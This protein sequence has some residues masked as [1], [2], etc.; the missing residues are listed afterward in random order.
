MHNPE[1]PSNPT[2]GKS[3]GSTPRDMHREL[4]VYQRRLGTAAEEAGDF[5]RVLFLAHEL[6]N[7]ITAAYLREAAES[8]PALSPILTAVGKRVLGR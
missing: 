3:R 5:E 6:N 7:Q 1:L 4:R 2:P 8:L